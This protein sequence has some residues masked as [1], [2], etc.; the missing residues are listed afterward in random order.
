MYDVDDAML[1]TL[2]MLEEHPDHYV[3]DDIQV[4]MSCAETGTDKKGEGAIQTCITYFLKNY[5][6]ELLKKEHLESYTTEGQK[7]L[8]ISVDPE[9]IEFVHNI[10]Y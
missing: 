1:K 9:T 10:K 7:R 4:Q 6:D 3:R 2:D 5:R 8:K